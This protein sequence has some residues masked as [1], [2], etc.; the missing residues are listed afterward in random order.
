MRRGSCAART[1]RCRDLRACADEI[2]DEQ[3]EHENIRL[4]EELGPL[5]V[6]QAERL[7][8]IDAL[9][10]AGDGERLEAEVAGELLMAAA[11][12]IVPVDER[13]GASAPVACLLGARSTDVGGLQQIPARHRIR[14]RVVIDVLV[15]FVGA[16]DPVEVCCSVGIETYA[17]RPVARR[18]AQD[19]AAGTE[20]LRITAPALVSSY[21]PG[22][23]GGDVLLLLAGQD[24]DELAT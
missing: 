6:L 3:V 19:L 7:N 21:G 15:V 11:C 9:R 18:F 17:R 23:V 12:R 24:A 20:S 2:G 16:D 13:R 5:Q 1:S 4:L 10:K 14:E 8:G 22:D